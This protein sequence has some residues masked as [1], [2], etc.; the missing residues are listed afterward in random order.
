MKRQDGYLKRLT[1][2]IYRIPVIGEIVRRLDRFS[3][4]ESSRALSDS[5]DAPDITFK[6]MAR[7]IIRAV[8]FLWPMIIHIIGFILAGFLLTAIFAIV[9]AIGADMWNNKM[10]VND[11]LQPFQAFVIFA[12]NTYVEEEFLSEEELADVK[13]KGFAGEELTQDQRKTVRNGMLVWFLIGALFG[14]FLVGMYS[15]Y[16]A[17]VWQNVNHYLRVA[18][19]EKLEYLSLSFHQNSR[20]GDAIYRIYQDSSMIVS[21]LDECV[22]G[23]I[24]TIRDLMITIA[25][26]MAFDFVLG[27]SVL[28]TVIPMFVITAYATPLIRRLSVANRVANSEFTSRLQ[29][30]FSLLKVIKA[31]QMEKIAVDRFDKDSTRALDAALYIRFAMVVL[32]LVCGVL[33]GLVIIVAEYVIVNWTVLERETDIPAWTTW[34]VGYTFWNYALY[35]EANERVG[36]MVNTGRGLVRLW[37]TLQDLFIGLERAFYFLDLK[38]NVVDPPEPKAFP[39]AIESV[40]WQGVHFGYEANVPILRG[41]DLEA[42]PGSVTAI[43]G[44]TG[45]GK[46]TLM[47]LLLRLYDPQQGE[48]LINNTSV[49]EFTIEAIRDHSAIA[50]QKNVLFTGR[51]RD[52]ISYAQ[53]QKTMEEIQEAARIACADEFIEDMPDG[54]NTQL[55]ERGSK[56]SSGQR[57]RLTIARAVIRNTPILILDEPTASLDARTEHTVLS[58]LAEWGQDKVVF[59]I[60]HRLSTIRNADKIAFLKDGMIVETGSHDELMAISGGQYANFVEAEIVGASDTS[61]PVT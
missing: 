55:G 59:V 60:T 33:G 26:L 28:V 36:S 1:Q 16:P 47:S 49:K 41:V 53:D 18:M 15:Y 3:R 56:L 25:F 21:V 58:N 24:E 46:S 17:W 32:S 14:I 57:Q 2:E 10:L 54:Y 43:V 38:P 51:I 23:P 30:T 44:A 35:N 13:A 48:V 7:L 27:L 50:M 61:V 29:E 40:N 45:S 37:C 9:G 5:E 11:K 39:T 12:D 19:V 42:T 20:S 4:A 31:N 52:N 34:V 6:R 22:I 8:P